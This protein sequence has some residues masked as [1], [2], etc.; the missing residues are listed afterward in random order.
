MVTGVEI[1]GLVLAT[2]PLII[3]VVQER[4]VGIRPIDALIFTTSGRIK[5]S[6]ILS[7]Q[8][9]RFRFFCERLL[10]EV[11]VE[12]VA[13]YLSVNEN[14]RT[15]WAHPKL[16]ERFLERLGES[17]ENFDRKMKEVDERVTRIQKYT[18]M[19]CHKRWVEL[20]SN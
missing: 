15:I 8:R 20:C 2:L 7:D 17:Y 16:R 9:L 5:V 3:T 19:H 13:D 4:E 6:Q 10:C 18:S 11:G 12:N 1:A 14:T